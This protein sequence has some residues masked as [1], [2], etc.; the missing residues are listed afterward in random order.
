[1]PNLLIHLS[2]PN[3]AHSISSD[4]NIEKKSVYSEPQ[5]YKVFLYSQNGFYQMYLC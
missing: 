3:S 4:I 5:S 2:S 1:M